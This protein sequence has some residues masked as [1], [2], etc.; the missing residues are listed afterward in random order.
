MIDTDETVVD[1]VLQSMKERKKASDDGQTQATVVA[2]TDERRRRQRERTKTDKRGVTIVPDASE[3][4]LQGKTVLD[5]GGPREVA[6]IRHQN[7]RPPCYSKGPPMEID[8]DIDLSDLAA[9][10]VA[11][12]AVARRPGRWR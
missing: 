10:A 11:V 2:G 12:A 5:Q 1:T 6:Q 9:A 3:G 4:N 7:F 8:A